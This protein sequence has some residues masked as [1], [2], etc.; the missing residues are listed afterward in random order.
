[1]SVARQIYRDFRAID[2]RQEALP[3]KA[4][5]YTRTIAR[6]IRASR[7]FVDE[8]ELE[9]GSA[10]IIAQRTVAETVINNANLV[11]P[12]LATRSADNF[13][14]L[15]RQTCAAHARAR[16][17]LKDAPLTAAHRALANGDAQS[18]GGDVKKLVEVLP[19]ERTGRD[20][21]YAVQFCRTPARTKISDA[22]YG[23]RVRAILLPGSRRR[24]SNAAHVSR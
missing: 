19:A 5:V 1:M 9:A 23:S 16:L 18:N 7:S 17:A 14:T 24:G 3:V 11:A 21:R 20:R 8:A 6:T 10:E 4:V 2:P 15:L 12:V 13:S 22:L